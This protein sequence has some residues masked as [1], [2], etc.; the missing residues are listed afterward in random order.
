MATFALGG[1]QKYRR[2]G[3]TVLL[4]VVLVAAQPFVWRFVH[5]RALELQQKRSQGQ[6]IANV[7]ARNEEVKTTLK[8]QENFLNQL[9]VVSPPLTSL[10]QVVERVEQLADQLGLTVN[11]SVI[12]ELPA[13]GA[14]VKEEEI[15]PVSV[16]IEA[17][18]TVNQLLSFFDRVEHTQELSIVRTWSMAP[19]LA[20]APGVVPVVSTPSYVLTMDI[21]FFLQRIPNGG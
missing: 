8:N 18:G 3:T 1:N 7:K 20:P 9:Q 4:L 13:S 16:A 10:T 2:L 11:I 6:Q 21:L 5:A 19:D 17:K 15:V 14:L 12:Q